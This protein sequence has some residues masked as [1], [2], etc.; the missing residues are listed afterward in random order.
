MD[1]L[2]RALETKTIQTF[3]ATYILP[4]GSNSVIVSYVPLLDKCG[5]VSQIFGITHD[6][7]ERKRVEDD[8]RKSEAKN[9]SLLDAMPD[10][11]F[12]ISE[13]GTLL[14][15]RADVSD[16]YVPPGDFIGKKIQ[17]DASDV[18]A[19]NVF[20]G[21]EEDGSQVSVPAPYGQGPNRL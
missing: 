20:M 11:M 19:I 8:L 3:E 15:F 12:L 14:D 5:L 13:D 2:K 6:I 1:Y 7:T 16:L 17:D 9:R 4:S 21:G 10:A 18:P